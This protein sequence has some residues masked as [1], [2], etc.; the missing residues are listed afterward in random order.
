MKFS[1]S[2]L[3]LRRKVSCWWWQLFPRLVSKTGSIAFW[4]HAST[5]RD[6]GCHSFAKISW[7]QMSET[8][9]LSFINCSPENPRLKVLS[10]TLF[11]TFFHLKNPGM[12]VL[13]RTVFRTFVTWKP[14]NEGIVT[15][16][17]TFLP[18]NPGMKGLSR[19]LI[20]FHLKTQEWRYCHVLSFIHFSP[21]NP[22]M[23]GL[24]STL[25]HTFFTWK[26]RNEGI[27]RHSLSYFFTWKPG[28]EWGCNNRSR[29]MGIRGSTYKHGNKGK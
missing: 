1:S 29:N 15:Y 26:P 5:Q 17:H 22:G 10:R 2:S 6:I 27:V 12:K 7:T 18:E 16:S 23:K 14:T 8:H 9:K 4:L 19:T 25:F 11:H 20:H 3:S 13:S 21:E 28:S 24:T